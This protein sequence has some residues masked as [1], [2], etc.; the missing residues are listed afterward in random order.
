MTFEEFWNE[1]YSEQ[2]GSVEFPLEPYYGIASY[3]WEAAERETQRKYEE[4]LAEINR[5]LGEVV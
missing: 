5:R 2:F 3:A 4:R 1:N